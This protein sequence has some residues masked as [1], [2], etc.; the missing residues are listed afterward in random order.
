[1]AIDVSPS[2]GLKVQ[3][4][5]PL[6]NFADGVTDEET[7]TVAGTTFEFDTGDG[8]VADGNVMIS[9]DPGALAADIATAAADAVN[10]TDLGGVTAL[11]IGNGIGLIDATA[12]STTGSHVQPFAGGCP[13]VV[14]GAT[15]VTDGDTL[16]INGTTFEFDSNGSVAA[17]NTPIAFPATGTIAEIATATI[18]A[19]N[20]AGIGVTAADAGG[21]HRVFL[22]NTAGASACA[23]LGSVIAAASAAVSGAGI[24]VNPMNTAAGTLAMLNATSGSAT[25]PGVQYLG[26]SP[27]LVS[28]APPSTTAT[29]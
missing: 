9:V 23:P 20:G 6:V 17:G 25:G 10:A 7:F 28:A 11:N 3:P 13:L 1:M 12:V 29:S 15:T 16:T 14:F 2:D 21:G 8:V 5:T 19:I 18:T 27:L 22:A 26:L 24:G 4:G